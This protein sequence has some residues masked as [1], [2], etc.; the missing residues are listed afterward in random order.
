MYLLK[1]F[2]LVFMEALGL[3]TRFSAVWFPH[4]ILM[5]CSLTVLHFIY[6]HHILTFTREKK[7][8]L[9]W[10]WMD[11]FQPV[12]VIK[13]KEAINYFQWIL[14]AF[15]E[16]YFISALVANY[17][18]ASITYEV[19]LLSVSLLLHLFCTLSL[20]WIDHI[21]FLSAPFCI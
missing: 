15:E 12:Y 10:V 11:L 14:W 5:F 8:H 17:F 13:V 20:L 2:H 6:K 19:S 21:T 9:W 1:I 3:L 16:I 4:S 18:C 7:T